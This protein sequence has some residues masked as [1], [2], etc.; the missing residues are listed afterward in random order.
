M[1][2]AVGRAIFHGLAAAGEAGVRTVLDLPTSEMN[3]TLAVTD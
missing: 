2:G 1:H 3:T